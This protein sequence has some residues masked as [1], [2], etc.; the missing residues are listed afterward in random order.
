MT[1]MQK[2][3]AVFSGSVNPALADKIADALGA[4][5]GNVRLEKFANGEIYARYLESVR[6]ADVFIIQSVAG[7]HVNDAL[8]ELLI[9]ADAAKRASARTITAVITHYGYAR[10]DRKAAAREPIT[11]KLV[12]NLITTAGITRVMTIDLHQG[13][14]QGFFDMPVDHLTAL[15]ILA[16]YFKSKNLDPAKLCVVSPDVGRAK[17]AKKLS[18]MLEADLAI[19][20]KGRPGH[21][22][23]EITA[24]IGDVSG[25]VCILNDDMIDTGGSVVAAVETLKNKGAE[26][27]F[28][29][30]T[31]PVFSGPGLERMAN[32]DVEEVVVCDTIPV[33]AEYQTGKIKVVSVAPLFARAI[34]NVYNNGSVSDLFDPDFAL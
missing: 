21:N 14:I 34:S 11:A 7:S 6:G 8:M 5:L 3:M 2:S 23:A 10:Q 27:I 24:L 9:M 4:H 18:D 31:H 20:H 32:L 12:A 29:C 25:K 15:P 16:D 19:M 22:K 33:P 17:A 1:E 26:K 28:V 30:A 13:Q